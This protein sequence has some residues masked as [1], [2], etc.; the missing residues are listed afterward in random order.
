MESTPINKPPGSR[1]AVVPLDLVD[2]ALRFGR[3]GG[4]INPTAELVL[5]M[6]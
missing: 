6:R 5:C 4:R 3:F 1:Q 2:L